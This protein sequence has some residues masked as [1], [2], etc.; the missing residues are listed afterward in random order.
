MKSVTEL[1][2]IIPNYNYAQYLKECIDSVAASDF[3]HSRMEIIVVDDVSTDGS[4]RLLN[5]LK[6]G[7][8]IPF[9]IIV[10]PVN[11]GLAKARNTG[12]KAAKGKYL[13]FLDSDNYIRKECLRIHC[14]HLKKD[15]EAAACYAPIQK[16]ND[17][18]REMLGIFSNELFDY[19]KL[20]TGNYIDAMSMIR[21][22]DLVEQGLFDERM[23]HSG[24][25]DY[26]LWLRFGSHDKKMLFLE[27]EPLSYYRMHDDSMLN[28]I[29]DTDSEIL[30]TYLNQKYNLS[31][32]KTTGSTIPPNAM[33]FT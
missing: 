27:G 10:Q 26:E 30:C 15:K 5:K 21:K 16:F 2:V 23:P 1:S 29:T 18:S 20:K 3:D 13:F 33:I 25:E 11:L 31:L 6:E 32:R 24:W 8:D 7:T 19:N 22:S 4:L 14:E 9:H 12:I 17:Q 28:T